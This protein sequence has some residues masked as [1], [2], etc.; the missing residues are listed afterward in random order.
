MEKE[1]QLTVGSYCSFY[2]NLDKDKQECVIDFLNEQ[3]Y[4][5]DS[6]NRPTCRRVVN[7]Y[8]VDGIKT[9]DPKSDV[10]YL[11]I[12]NFRPN[13]APLQISF[14]E[15]ISTKY[16]NLSHLLIDGNIEIFIRELS[17]LNNLKVLDLR[18]CIINGSR[19]KDLT[20]KCTEL[21][22]KHT[23]GHV[24][25]LVRFCSYL[26]VLSLDLIDNKWKSK[27]TDCVGN[28]DI[29]IPCIDSLKILSLKGGEPIK[30]QI[31]KKE[32]KNLDTLMINMPTME[33]ANEYIQNTE[34]FDIFHRIYF[35][36]PTNGVI[37]NNI[38]VNLEDLKCDQLLDIYAPQLK[39]ISDNLLRR[40]KYISTNNIR[41]ENVNKLINAKKLYSWQKVEDII[42]ELFENNTLEIVVSKN[43]TIGEKTDDHSV[44]HR[45]EGRSIIK[46]P[47]PTTLKDHKFVYITK[48]FILHH[49]NSEPSKERKKY[50]K[51]ETHETY[52]LHDKITKLTI[53]VACLFAG[54]IIGALIK[55]SINIVN[56]GGAGGSGGNVNINK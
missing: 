36:I 18:N 9:L 7:Y 1:E 11:V 22:M 37:I 30:Y 20:L 45:G 21:F 44:Y 55:S 13:N 17:C 24:G 47:L 43:I 10:E 39:H 40:A 27:T 14:G 26:E 12:K 49:T 35:G 51:S 2:N 25:E 3:K 42:G 34:G 19:E 5:T 33:E 15:N 54:I 48:E 28:N 4:V 52:K 16:T 29:L 32:F 8:G 38:V 23:K 31:K 6:I 41:K 53:G 56:E 50:N 46:V